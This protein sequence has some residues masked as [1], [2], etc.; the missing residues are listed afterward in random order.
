MRDEPGKYSPPGAVAVI[1]AGGWGTALACV[2]ARGGHSVRLWAR[3]PEFA[4][5]VQ[6]RRENEVYLPD[7][8]LA[9]GISV[10]SDPATAVHGA[11]L[12][13]FA[14]P[15]QAVGA[16]A[17]LFGPHL[18]LGVPI[19]SAS[20]GIDTET[21][22]RPTEIL[23]AM[24]RNGGAAAPSPDRPILCISGPNFASEI[25]RGLP[26]CSVLACTDTEIAGQVRAWFAGQSSLRIYTRADVTGVE[27]GGALKNVIAILAGIADGMALGLNARAAIITRG[28]AEIARLGVTMGADPLTFAGLSGMGDLVLTCTGSLSRNQWAGRELGQGRSVSEIVGGTRMVIEG[29]ATTKAAHILAQRYGVDMPLTSELHR[30]LFEDK[31]VREMLPSL[32]ARALRDEGE[33]PSLRLAQSDAKEGSAK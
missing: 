14:T 4:A 29:V 18:G 20:K 28:L 11:K 23:A 2:L 30:V 32:L 3:R 26:A 33:Y 12:V 7:V 13:V 15:A 6:V 10:T 9:P 25:A 31:P 19:V 22:R 27:L 16:M 17:D 5:H 1:G 21:L 24:G 8:A